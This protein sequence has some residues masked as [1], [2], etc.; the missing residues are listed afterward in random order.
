M[1]RQLAGPHR[2]PSPLVESAHDLHG[3]F[4]GPR[5]I[6][7]FPHD[8][9]P[10]LPLLWVPFF[11]N[12]FF[13]NYEFSFL[14]ITNLVFEGSIHL[15]FC[16]LNCVNKIATKRTS[17]ISPSR[18]STSSTPSSP[19]PSTPPLLFATKRP[20]KAPPPRLPPC[21]RSMPPRSPRICVRFAR[22][23]TNYSSYF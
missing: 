14:R 21:S 17:S 12:L 13:T 10:H 22:S 19:S 5:R 6:L 11:T 20:V 9:R 15:Q 1:L 3:L 18:P 7:P 8:H 16:L 23:A 2:G 4:P